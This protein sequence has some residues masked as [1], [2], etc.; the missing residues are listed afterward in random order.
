MSTAT[1]SNSCTIYERP[2]LQPIDCL[3][4][5]DCFINVQNPAKGDTVACMKLNQIKYSL[6]SLTIH[7]AFQWSLIL[8]IGLL[9][10]ACKQETKVANANDASG[11]YTLVTVNGNK[12]PTKMAHDGVGLEIRSGAFTINADGTCSSKMVFVPPTGT[13]ATR[14]GSAT[15]TREGSKLKMQWKGAGKT[16]GTI[17]GNTFTMDNEGMVLTYKK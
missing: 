4:V 5:A 2:S 9:L 13:E 15:Y 6:T 12:V 8:A 16:V 1:S 3:D 17:E 14:D 10:S 11:I 7:N